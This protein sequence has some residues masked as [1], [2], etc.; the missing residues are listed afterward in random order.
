MPRF[1]SAEERARYMVEQ[2][3]AVDMATA[4]M[5]GEPAETGFIA[6]REVTKDAGKS[7]PPRADDAGGGQGRA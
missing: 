1:A 7:Q 3:I 6:P 4:L 2:G 5:I